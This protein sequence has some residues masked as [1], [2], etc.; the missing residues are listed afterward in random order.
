MNKRLLT[1]LLLCASNIAIS[2]ET[3]DIK[4]MSLTVQVS[5]HA[6]VETTANLDIKLINGKLTSD[7]VKL[8]QGSEIPY[9]D[10]CSRK[11]KI[12]YMFKG[13]TII[14][15]PGELPNTF[16]MRLQNDDVDVMQQPMGAA[17]TVLLPVQSQ[18]SI[19]Q[20]FSI[21]EPTQHFDFKSG[22]DL[23][24]TDLTYKVTINVK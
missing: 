9:V 3:P 6:N 17:C 10:S 15:T 8:K 5:R 14:V 11:S 16:S 24:Y 21:V 13:L 20:G 19:T 4:H 7:E 1:A 2:A 23:G 18:F 22:K 12:S